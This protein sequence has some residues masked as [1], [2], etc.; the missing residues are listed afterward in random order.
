MSVTTKQCCI[1]ERRTLLKR[2]DPE[3]AIGTAG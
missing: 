2:K 3:S 1:K